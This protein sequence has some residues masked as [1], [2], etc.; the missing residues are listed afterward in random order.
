MKKYRFLIVVIFIVLVSYLFLV[1]GQM[2]YFLF[3][4][5]ILSFTIP[6][7]HLLIGRRGIKGSVDLPRKSVF[8]GET[9]QIKYRIEN[10][11]LVNIP[12]LRIENIISKNLTGVEPTIS[13]I[14]LARKKDYYNSEALTLTRRG[15][16]ELGELNLSFKD[17]FGIYNLSKRISSSLSLLVYP[18]IIKL[19]AININTSLQT[20]EL[21]SNKVGF[22]D[23]SRIKSL[24]DYVES[25]SVKDIHWKLSINRES[26]LLKEYESRGDN[27]VYIFLD[28][29]EIL[30]K[31]D[32]D[33]RLEDKAA[34]VALSI[35]DYFLGHN[36]GISLTT[37]IQDKITVI[38]GNNES[39]IKAFLD[40]LA[41]FKG[42]G[43][44][45]LK[46]LLEGMIDSIYQGSSLIIIT[47]NLEKSLG[48]QAIN[49]KMR[50][51]I[52]Q[53]IYVT[54]KE[55]HKYS[56]DANLLGSL[57]KEGISL[58]MVDFKKST[59]EALEAYNES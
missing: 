53:I 35:L 30:Y 13:H 37:Q 8:P 32:F 27:K 23:K 55:N 34:E 7:F 28:N 25:D 46:D 48:S 39:E 2:P 58:V 18:E 9:L 16:Y 31:N 4:V 36:I 43:K 3:Y 52:P 24:R 15:Y 29:Q 59:K 42:N 38:E 57:K 56:T 11:S 1:G 54:D 41:Y 22:Q 6:F 47:P 45:S 49:L 14:S 10:N 33:R 26:P 21:L 44:L 19:S 17:V 50:N 40:C 51:I 12:Y 5:F 20:G